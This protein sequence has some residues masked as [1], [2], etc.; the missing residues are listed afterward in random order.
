M[1]TRI[2]FLC[3]I[4]SFLGIIFSDFKI[5]FAIVGI[6]SFSI[7]YVYHGSAT[8]KDNNTKYTTKQKLTQIHLTKEHELILKVLREN[9]GEFTS[10]QSI[11]RITEIEK[12]LIN[13]IL[14]E[15]KQHGLVKVTN[16]DETKGGHQYQLTD[17]GRLK[18]LKIT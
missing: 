13:I 18:A 9:D 4:I 12:I 7:A 8:K 5:H 3:G 15:L 1:P 17:A 16:I 2:G 6:I 10:V 14:G 11:L